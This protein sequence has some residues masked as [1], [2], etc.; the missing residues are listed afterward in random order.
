MSRLGL[1]PDDVKKRLN[2]TNS[3][4]G[5]LGPDSTVNPAD[6][7]ESIEEQESTVFSRCP[8]IYLPLF[9]AVPGEIVIRSAIGGETGFVLGLA[10]VSDVLIY[11]N[12]TTDWD[13]RKPADALRDG[14]GC[15]IDLVT[16]TVT[17]TGGRELRAGDS[18][19]AEYS[20]NA[21]P[22][23]HLLRRITIDLTA[24]E[25]ARRLYP[26]DQRWDRYAEWE[27]RAWY[28]LARM[29]NK[30]NERM[31]IEMFDKLD[32]IN[33]TY[34]SRNVGGLGFSTDGYMM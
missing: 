29:R 27:K 5:F 7:V 28:D 3:V 4:R 15:S 20:H 25:W 32:L 6:V 26:D 1:V 34:V 16:G 10:P 9:T 17:L 31:G 19:V 33:E 11:I 24:A 30:D 14:H 22:Q 2:P 8:A 13:S 12:L 23:C 21:M 18:V